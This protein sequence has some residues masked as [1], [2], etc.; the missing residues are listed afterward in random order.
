[1]IKGLAD[2]MMKHPG[3]EVSPFGIAEYYNDLIGA[4]IIMTKKM[5][6]SND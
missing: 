5:H 1:V 2:R 4:M 3:M 6:P